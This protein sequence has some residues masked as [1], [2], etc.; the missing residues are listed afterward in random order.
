M[1]LYNSVMTGFEA[2]LSRRGGYVYKA[3]IVKDLLQTVKFI[4]SFVNPSAFTY[5][6]L[7]DLQRCGDKDGILEQVATYEHSSS[8][9][10]VRREKPLGAGTRSNYVLA[11][12]RFCEFLHGRKDR[13]LSIVPDLHSWATLTQHV[14]RVYTTYNMD[15]TREQAMRRFDQS[16][17][18]DGV[19]VW[20]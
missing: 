10:M 11:L 1:D 18:L 20:G 2:F 5:G 6:S 7:R 9:T 17:L 4:V 19:Q 15:K 14:N 3:C 12:K 13:V 8:G 16:Q